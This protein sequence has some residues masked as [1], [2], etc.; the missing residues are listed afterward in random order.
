MA[1]T[2]EV[3]PTIDSHYSSCAV[4]NMPA[5]PAGPCD[6]GFEDR[7]RAAIDTERA[8]VKVLEAALNGSIKRLGEYENV[9][10]LKCVLF[11]DYRAILSA[12]LKEP[13]NG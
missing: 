6:C 3:K 12:A 7:L 9:E 10:A 1:D 4:H 8:R 2:I 5:Y 13:A 11:A